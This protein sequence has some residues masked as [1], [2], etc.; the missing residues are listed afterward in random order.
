MTLIDGKKRTSYPES[1]DSDPVSPQYVI[2]GL[3]LNNVRGNMNIV[4]VSQD[5]PQYTL[6]DDIYHEQYN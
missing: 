5:E 3:T 4:S 1:D 6:A 2:S